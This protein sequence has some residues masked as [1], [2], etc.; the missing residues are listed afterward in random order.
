MHGQRDGL[1]VAV[2]GGPIL[3]LLEGRPSYS[4]LAIPLRAIMACAQQRG[5]G[6]HE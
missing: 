6:P 2:R 5:F 3:S 1:A 4:N